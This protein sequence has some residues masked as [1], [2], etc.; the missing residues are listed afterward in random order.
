MPLDQVVS[1][2]DIINIEM[3]IEITEQEK[4][5]HINN[6]YKTETAKDVIQLALESAGLQNIDTITINDIPATFQKHVLFLKCENEFCPYEYLTTKDITYVP[7]LTLHVKKFIGI[8][9]MHQKVS[10]LS[11]VSKRAHSFL[12]SFSDFWR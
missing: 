2:S 8:K 10:F 6:A 3:D 5:S 11:R 9:S 4:S 12:F 1:S 7:C